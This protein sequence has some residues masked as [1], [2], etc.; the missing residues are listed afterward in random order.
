[1]YIHIYVLTLYPAFYGF[2]GIELANDNSFL[3]I[4]QK[5]KKYVDPSIVFPYWV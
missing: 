3:Y 4:L 1:M 5:R 2:D